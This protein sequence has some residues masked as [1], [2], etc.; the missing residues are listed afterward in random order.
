MTNNDE[1]TSVISDWDSYNPIK[2]YQ[3]IYKSDLHKKATEYFDKEVE[4][5]DFNFEKDRTL[6]KAINHEKSVNA[7]LTS[8]KKGLKAGM[9]L[10]FVLAAFL[11]ICAVIAYFIN[12][13]S[14][15]YAY[16]GG[17]KISTATIL[18]IVFSVIC[19]ILA[20]APFVVL[21]H[22]T[23]KQLQSSD[24]LLK[25]LLAEARENLTPILNI[26]KHGATQQIINE[27]IPEIEIYKYFS[28]KNQYDFASRS[29]EMFDYIDNLEVSC[30]DVINGTINKFP[31]VISKLRRHKMGTKTYTGHLTITY[32]VTTT[33]ANG[34]RVTT[35]R[36][37]VLTATVTKPCP[38]YSNHVTMYYANDA[39]PNLS[40]KRERNYVHQ[41]NSDQVN[42][43]IKKKTK[44]FE[45]LT[46]AATKKGKNFTMLGNNKFEAL[47][48]CANRD[49]EMEYRLMF[50]PLAQRSMTDVLLDNKVF[51][52]DSFDFTKSKKINAIQSD[53]LDRLE[54]T[55]NDLN[56]SEAY[57]FNMLKT[58]FLRYNDQF[59]KALYS[60]L[61]PALSIPLYLK[62]RPIDVIFDNKDNELNLSQWQHEAL[63][64]ESPRKARAFI[65]PKNLD[66]VAMYKTFSIG[67]DDKSDDV[68][69]YAWGYKIIPQIDYV[70]VYGNDGHTHMVPVHWDLYEPVDRFS[71]VKINL[72]NNYANSLAYNEEIKERILNNDMAD[73]MY[74]V[75]STILEYNEI[76][77]DE[78]NHYK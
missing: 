4:K 19:F 69:V 9:I 32:T 20:I 5:T 49:N 65:N 62:Q 47:W 14:A 66:T 70:P 54:F 64:N 58:E 61:V 28:T 36:T 11:A 43:L 23:K 15:K 73:K 42:K 46:T 51:Y 44:E 12:K 63:V 22:K 8:R 24:N 17:T 48:N 29:P 71:K 78:I 77:K 39:A 60:G 57:S 21:F 6:E 35:V 76:L 38:Y 10:F 25:K 41:L 30:L 16:N 37:Q 3:D 2:N 75:N 34:N 1:K 18:F 68:G 27:T 33:D 40:F 67:K 26:F 56:I 52:G 13:E 72:L 31:F 53:A 50:T 59:F 7:K 45:K 74:Q 55:F